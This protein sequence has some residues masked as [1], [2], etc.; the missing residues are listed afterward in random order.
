MNNDT[1]VILKRPDLDRR[2]AGAYK[3]TQLV[4]PFKHE[5]KKINEVNKPEKGYTGDK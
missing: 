2:K 4:V 3:L 1:T 5:K